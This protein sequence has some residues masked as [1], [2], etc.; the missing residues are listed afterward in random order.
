MSPLT[1]CFALHLPVPPDGVIASS[2]P[3]AF[4]ADRIVETPRDFDASNQSN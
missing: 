1:Y 2:P 4:L 3:M